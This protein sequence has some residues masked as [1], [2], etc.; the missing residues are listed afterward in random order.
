M[1]FLIRTSAL[2]VSL[3]LLAPVTVLAQAADPA[4]PDNFEIPAFIQGIQSAADF[5]ALTPEQ[6]A[7]AE[8]FFAAAGPG[9]LQ[10]PALAAPSGTVSCF[11]YYTF[12]SVQVS[13]SPQVD[14]TVSGVPIT[15]AGTID[16]ENPYPV[17]DGGVYMK[18]FRLTD[19]GTLPVNGY[20]VVDQY[21]VAE[22]LTLAAASSRPISF[23]W[24]VPAGLPSGDYQAAFYYTSAKRFNLLGLP[25]TDDVVGNT[26][27]FSVAGE[28]SDTAAF[29]KD[30]V[31]VDGEA[32]FFAA[33]TPQVDP[34]APITVTADLANDTS[35]TQA[36][37]VTFTTYAWDQQRA[38]NIVNQVTETITVPAGSTTTVTHT[39]TDTTSSVYLV[40]AETKYLDTKSLLN[41]RF[42]RS[43]IPSV[44]INYP[45]VTSYP[46]LAGE[47]ATFL[48]C[49]H[50]AGTMDLIE[51]GKL[52]LRLTDAADNLVHRY[53]YEGNITG[54]M[55]A[56]QDTFTP[57][58]T[59]DTFTLT[60][61]LY[62]DNTLIEEVDMVYDCTQL[63][64]CVLPDEP[65][66]AITDEIAVRDVI[67]MLLSILAL[68]VFMAALGYYFF[69]RRP[70]RGGS[71]RDMDDAD[72]DRLAPTPTTDSKTDPKPPVALWLAFVVGAAV[73]LGGGH[74]AAAQVGKSAVVNNQLSGTLF[75]QATHQ[76]WATSW[77]I[78]LADPNVSVTYEASA[79]NI[80]TSELIAPNDTIAV[81]TRLRFEPDRGQISW[82]GTGY[83][84]DTPYGTW[85]NNAA[86]P[87]GTSIDGWSRIGSCLASDY[88]G[89]I[90]HA[91]G[92]FRYDV[93]V[94]F[95]VHPA[96]MTVNV[97]PSTAGLSLI[98]T[99]TYEVTSPGTIQADFTYDATYGQFYYEYIQ[100]DNTTNDR[101]CLTSYDE[102]PMSLSTITYP[103]NLYDVSITNPLVSY[104]HTIPAVTIPYSITV[105][106]P[107]ANVPPTAP[108]IVDDPANT[109]QAG[110]SQ[111]F[112]VTATDPDGN[113]LRYGIDWDMNGTVD[114]WLPGTGYTPSGN[115]LDASRLWVTGGDKDFQVLAEDENAARSAFTTHSIT[116]CGSGF[117][118]NSTTATCEAVNP[119]PN[120][121]ADVS[122]VTP[123]AGFDSVTGRYDDISLTY[124]VR[125]TATA[126]AGASVLRFEVDFDSN[127][128]VDDTLTVNIAALSGGGESGTAMQQLATDV[129]SGAHRVVVTVD[130]TDQVTESDEDD[131]VFTRPVTL[132]YPDPSIELT[133][134][135]TLVRSGELTTVSWNTNATYDLDCRLIGPGI[136]PAHPFNPLTDGATGALPDIGP[137]TAKS[138]YRLTCTTP[139]D[140]TFTDTAT[141]ETTGTVEEI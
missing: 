60:A 88:M 4:S 140:T 59:L 122:A 1:S 38:E 3:L 114:Q 46:L 54:A 127:G 5:A 44:R 10:S 47:E 14:S 16:N 84:I 30:S 103:A 80:D 18:I 69:R 120:L 106:G 110:I 129:P 139:D 141:V 56:V 81:G 32:Y 102:L 118:W 45:A 126:D 117:A 113:Q 78:G 37:P 62:R 104:Q 124:N 57:A 19:D 91:Y 99:N 98:G 77:A 42:T 108:S 53:T 41:I 121:T 48:S 39:V 52:E 43:D 2:C 95:S 131:N 83:A 134:N 11:D 123:S 28:I 9:A 50:G 33:F 93:Y 68:L 109:H 90:Q 130:Y 96:A 87:T 125:N 115:T 119:L 94:P 138:E 72:Q 22:D 40:V 63:D 6:R 61:A 29:V 112:R 105:A 25:F 89:N 7:E 73:F 13:V 36:L 31:T 66:A 82:N 35:M 135:P 75:Y 27:S 137:I 23:S 136:S 107:P 26:L 58:E 92:P 128:S 24:D 15:F 79:Y 55:M 65:I 49:L 97:S 111:M 85:T 34:A 100:T 8:A 76:L 116:L 86:R 71:H 12:G 67:T 101:R 64:G 132:T 21:F 17:V 70:D 20:D 133:V 51:G 74:D